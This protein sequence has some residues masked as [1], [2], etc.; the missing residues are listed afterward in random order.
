MTKLRILNFGS[1]ILIRSIV[2][3]DAVSIVLNADISPAT[4]SQSK[5]RASENIAMAF[6]AALGIRCSVFRTAAEFAFAEGN[7]PLSRFK[8]WRAIRGT[9]SDALPADFLWR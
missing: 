5:A 8:T 2:V 3:G 6:V 7:M 9:R 4:A 1:E